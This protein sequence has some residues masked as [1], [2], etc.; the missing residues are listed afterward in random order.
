MSDPRPSRVCVAA[1]AGAYGVRGEAR[2]KSFTADPLAF[3]DY[4]PL[5]SEDGARQF[6][7]KVTRPVAGGFA[8]RL[9]GVPTREAAEALKGTRLYAPRDRLPPLETDEFY[10]ADLIGLAA[11]DTGGAALGRVLAVDD[12]GAGDVIDIGG[13]GLRTLT[14][15]FTR[16]V[17]PTV[18]IAQ[19]RVVIDPPAEVIAPDF[20][21]EDAADG[22]DG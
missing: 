17:V 20:G 9:G 16:A 6:S 2:V 13:P 19:G 10:H 5:E 11:F 15:P 4:A 3:A 7:V 18:D 12:F 21:K 1:I 8:A 14:L 22:D